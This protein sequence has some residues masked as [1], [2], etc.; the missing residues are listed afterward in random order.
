MPRFVVFDILNWATLA[1]L[2]N[3]DACDK[4]EKYG[5]LVFRAAPEESKFKMS[6]T[7]KFCATAPARESVKFVCK[8]RYVQYS[9]ILLNY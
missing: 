8:P 6:I 1:N 2:S 9:K 7:K 4:F 3:I 5:P